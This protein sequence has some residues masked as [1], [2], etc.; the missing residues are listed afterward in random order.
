MLQPPGTWGRWSSL[1]Q[2]SR[3]QP[4]QALVSLRKSKSMV[5]GPRGRTSGQSPQL[6]TPSHLVP[7]ETGTSTWLKRGRA[8]RLRPPRACP[9]SGHDCGPSISTVSTA[10]SPLRAV[11]LGPA[12][13][14]LHLCHLSSPGD[15]LPFQLW[16]PCVN[17]HQW[18]AAGPRAELPGWA[19]RALVTGGSS[20]CQHSPDV[21]LAGL[22]AGLCHS[23][24][25]LPGTAQDRA[26]NTGSLNPVHPH[27]LCSAAT[28]SSEFVH[29]AGGSQLVSEGRKCSLGS[30]WI[31]RIF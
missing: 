20:V 25:G 17:D 21:A 23:R 31:A 9:R 30:L 11:S 10:P 3:F 15:T 14:L 13:L 5:L 7:T 27:Q 29:L 2:E 26:G 24:P 6:P 4:H 8:L 19:Q 16:L 22:A 18:E 12:L 1:S 28:A